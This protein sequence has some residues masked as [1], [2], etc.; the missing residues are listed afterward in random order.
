[1]NTQA[2]IHQVDLSI[3]EANKNIRRM[4]ALIK[5]SNNKE[6]KEIFLD[7]YFNAFAIKQVLLRADPTQQSEAD[8]LQIMKNIDAIGAL[9]IH[10]QS[11]ITLGRQ[12]EAAIQDDERTREELLLEEAA[13]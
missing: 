6:Y 9:R 10:L 12:S 5:L 1:M 4:N 8:Q 13:A 11:V 7:G 2:Q 3:E